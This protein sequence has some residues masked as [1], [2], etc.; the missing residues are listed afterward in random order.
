VA[1][2]LL[3][4]KIKDS[5]IGH[6]IKG[7]A[8]GLKAIALVKNKWKF[9]LNT[10]LIWGCYTASVIVSFHA[11]P[12]TENLPMLAGLSIISFGSIGMI[13][14]PGGIGAYPIIVAKVL[15]LYGLAEG[16]GLAYGSVSWAAQ[17]LIIILLGLIALILLPLNN[18]NKHAKI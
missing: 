9:F 15:V 2:I 6:V 10:I 12:E 14:T 1:L 13:L 16:L 11:L 17:T 4:K 5:K 3:Y 7:I 18:R 8:E